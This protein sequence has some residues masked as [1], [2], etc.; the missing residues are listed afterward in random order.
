MNFNVNRF[1]RHSKIL[2]TCQFLTVIFLLITVPSTIQAAITFRGAEQ[3]AI[4]SFA[5]G[6]DITH[7]G[8]GTL[9]TVNGCGS[10]N[11][12]IPAGSVGDLLI[13]L[14]VI[15]E[16]AATVTMGGWNQYFTDSRN[17]FDVYI[18]WRVAT[19][20]DTNTITSGG[21]G[22]CRS[23]IGQISR[24][25]G[26]DTSSPFETV[27]PGS[28]F[29]GAASTDVITGQITTSLPEAMLVVAGFIADD[30]PL[31]AADVSVDAFTQSFD[32]QSSLGRDSAISLHFQLQ[33]T[34]GLKGI[35]S[36]LKD[37]P[38]TPGGGNG[39][40]FGVLL[41][42][43]PATPPSGLTINVPAG[44]TINDLMT[45]VVAV[46]PSS[47][48]INPPAGWI[49]LSRIDQAA[50]NS[51]AQEVFFRVATATE[52]ASYE[53][54][55][56]AAITGAAGGIVTYTGVDTGNPFDIFAGN[57]TPNGTSHT[58]NSVTTTVTDAMLISVHS[59]SSSE[60][61]T[62]PAGMTERVDIASITPPA[63]AGIALEIN[64][65]LQPATGAT[66]N[67]TATAAGS[68]DTGVAHLLALR[69]FIP[70]VL[71]LYYAMDEDVWLGAGSVIDSSGN[72]NHGGPVN[73]VSTDNINRAVSG[74]PGTC[75]YGVIPNNTDDSIDAIDT[76]FT[77]GN[78]GSITFWYNSNENWT[79]GGTNNRL[80]FDASNN[81]G[82]NNADKQ[83]FI[84]RRN[85]AGGSLRFVL[86][87][88]NDT[89]LEATATGLGFLANT[90]VH[91]GVTWDLPNDFLEIY[92][93]GVSVA[94]DNTNTNGTIGNINDLYI[95]D[96]R[97]TATGGNGW[98]ND[99]TNGLIDE[100]RIY[101]SAVSSGI[102]NNDRLAVHLCV[103]HYAVSYPNGP[104]GLTCEPSDVLITGHKVNDTA[105]NPAAGNVLTL[106]TSTGT[107]VW[108]AVLVSGTGIWSDSTL[109]DGQASYTW[110]GTESSFR[111]QMQ[112]TTAVTLDINLLDSNAVTESTTVPAEDPPINFVDTAF[113]VTDAGPAAASIG[114]QIAAK[115]SDTGFGAQTLFLQAIRTDTNTGACVGVFQNQTVI[116]DM[117]S[118]CNN[119]TVCEA[120]SG[121]PDIAMTVEDNTSTPVAI[122]VNNFSG[123]NPA[124]YENVTL[125]FDV[126]SK[127]PLVLNYPDAGRMALHARFQFPAP[128][129][130][131]FMT[132]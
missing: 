2:T 115:D 45:A 83:F 40:N 76:N 33:T 126:D 81:L 74:D 43:K 61:W 23:L 93:N 72:N 54:T 62:P 89:D 80:L 52:P 116:V 57:T 29:Q 97:D 98:S 94:T 121:G 87:D 66:G 63:A 46:R 88:S 102:I 14:V 22:N 16:E 131:T 39:R 118:E 48:T 90:W 71:L 67:K 55:F 120:G 4:A 19:G 11:P 85:I 108:Q 53:W 50:G 127:A 117:G 34:A 103:D 75:G 17:N 28:S 10:I 92:I 128:P 44:T 70:P 47:V 99:S 15:K 1:R 6:V 41:G 56:S 69:P 132:G 73:G 64:D 106:N 18:F 125:D 38:N 36:W 104:T 105:E 60:T 13:A 58:A 26:V 86:E 7:V 101:D 32:S 111:V 65:V 42:L 82:N 30:A 91:V 27:T 59:Y 31:N 124:N 96:N 8:A 114:I 110:P 51:N 25:S 12:S 3:N 122:G 35:F 24:F 5:P 37:P 130:S 109:N 79:G 100:V 119:P 20:S 113:R 112:H 78:Q 68:A 9:D 84:I 95:G 129:P 107:G 123:G 49:S 21:A 77:P